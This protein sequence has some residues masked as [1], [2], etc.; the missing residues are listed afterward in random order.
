M[1]NDYA[2]LQQAIANELARADL[3]SAIPTFIQL[4]EADF[5]RVLRTRFQ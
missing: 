2:S 5:N 3:T 4:A 1:I